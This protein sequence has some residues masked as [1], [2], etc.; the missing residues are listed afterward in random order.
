MTLPASLTETLTSTLS[1]FES[2]VSGRIL[3]WVLLGTGLYLTLGS[4]GVQLRLFARTARLVARSRHQR[5]SLSSFQAFVIGLGGRVGTGNIAGVA[6]AVTLGGPG[7]LFWMWVVALLGMATSFAEST[8]AQVFKVRNAD[9][10]FRGGPAYYMQRGLGLAGFATTGRAMGVLFAAML[11]FSYGLIFPMVQSNTIAATL[12]EA[13][14]LPT[15]ATAVALMVLTAPILLAGMRVV[16]RVTE[17]LVPLMAALYLVVVAVVI[18]I[19]LDRVPGVLADV[20]AGAFHLRAGLAGTG[21]GLFATFLNGTKRGLF[22]NEAGQGSSPNGAATA[23]VAHPVVQGLIQGFGVFMDTIVICTATGLTV[24]LASPAVY[25]P[26]VEPQWAETTLVQHALADILP[27]GW[28][29][30]FMSIVVLTF[31]Y[32]SV[33]GYSTFAEVNVSYLGGGRRPGI[34][35][36]LAMTV[37]T[38]LGAVVALDLAWVM[39]DVALALM[40]I[41]NLVA[42]LWL[43]RWVFGVL[44][45]YDRQRAEGVAEPAFIAPGNPLLPAE[46]PGDVWTRDRA[47]ERV[48][49]LDEG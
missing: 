48:E 13:H 14:G 7:A 24:L 41:L 37:A 36:R 21:G 4:R 8:L 44:R 27:G 47:R 6:L 32:S 38:G 40:T 43:S 28:V 31:A 20:F 45:D 39:A 3:I 34:V 22:S 35:L 12:Q 2:L 23:D 16:A 26:G 29:V 42:V 5:G 18:L 15:A 49:T 1:S 10:I 9:G 46:L 25:T 17:W 33:L 11:V 30:W 19:S